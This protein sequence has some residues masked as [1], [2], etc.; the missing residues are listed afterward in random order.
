MITF[1][2]DIDYPNA[3]N[4]SRHASELIALSLCRVATIS[5]IRWDFGCRSKRI[6]L[7][8]IDIAVDCITFEHNTFK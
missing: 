6:N 1:C 8:K 4:F 7:K 3:L 5:E 2:L